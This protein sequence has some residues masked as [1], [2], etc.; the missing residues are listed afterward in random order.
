MTVTAGETKNYKKAVQKVTVYVT[1]QKM[2]TAA[3]FFETERKT[4][5]KMEEAGRSKRI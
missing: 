5:C 2:G 1:P 3:P 4:D